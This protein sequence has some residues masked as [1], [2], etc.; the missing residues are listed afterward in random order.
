MA[1]IDLNILL[2]IMN[3]KDEHVGYLLP[4]AHPLVQQ[5]RDDLDEQHQSVL[6][7]LN[8]APRNAWQHFGNEPFSIEIHNLHYDQSGGLKFAG[9]VKKDGET[10]KRIDGIIKDI[11]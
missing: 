4:V 8:T 7:N 5:A 11:Y 1:D 9:I 2:R 10:T 3:S 6:K